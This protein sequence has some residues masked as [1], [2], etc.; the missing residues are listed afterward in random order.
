MVVGNGGRRP[1]A[2]SF[3]ERL[4]PATD[5]GMNHP[6]SYG[7]EDDLERRNGRRTESQRLAGMEPP[8]LNDGTPCRGDRR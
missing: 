8:A 1:F 5:A 6:S 3:A 7:D 2:R 4:A